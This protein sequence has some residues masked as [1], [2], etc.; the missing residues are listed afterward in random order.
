MN[1]FDQKARDWDKNKMNLD[2]TLAI[3]G[4]LGKLIS[5]KPPLKALEFGAGT[6]LLS[7]YLKDRFSEI[8]LM[9]TS[10][11][12]LKIA[13]LKMDE[14]D[15]SKFRTL[16]FNLENE[17]Y[18]GEKF[19][20]IY[21]QMVLHHIK[22]PKAIFQKFHRLLNPGGILAIADLY[23]EDGSFHD[24]NM[25][26]HRGFDPEKL[27]STLIKQGFQNCKIDP[28]FV[29]RKEISEGIIKDYPI[30]LMTTNR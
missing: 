12:M 8:T 21:S 28:C 15:R 7:F 3:V 11:E 1:D 18:S 20:I 19:D 16:F 9:D 30:F 13:E 17:E 14:N 26:V 27:K 5:D 10:R 23:L 22:S 6:G 2:R 29:M 25:D 4:K 24:Y